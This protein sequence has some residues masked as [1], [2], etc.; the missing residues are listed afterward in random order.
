MQSLEPGQ[1]AENRCGDWV[2]GL[3]QI[4]SRAVGQRFGHG[5]GELLGRGSRAD[6]ASAAAG[7][8]GRGLKYSLFITLTR[9]AYRKFYPVN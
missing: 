3:V 6:A 5:P 2:A 7:I 4:L 8:T 1:T 9:D